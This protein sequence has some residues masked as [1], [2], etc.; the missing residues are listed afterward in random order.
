MSSPHSGHRSR[1]K[2]R[3][4]VTGMNGFSQHEK[5]ELILFY[6]NPRG[7]VNPLAHRLMEKYHT[8]SAIFDAPF[9]ELKNIEGVGEH[10][11]TFLKLIPDLC[12]EYM[13]EIESGSQTKLVT[14]QDICNF[15]RY[16]FIGIKEEVLYAVYMDNTCKVLK[17]EQISQGNVSSLNINV[18]KL[19]EIALSCNA[20]TVAIAHNHPGGALHPSAE[21]LEAT[22]HIVE[23]F[24]NL[25]IQLSDHVIISGNNYLSLRQSEEYCYVFD[26]ERRFSF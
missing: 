18:R 20:T 6:T 12:R 13:I 19:T 4:R 8:L 11:A 10:T 5:L 21:D 3:Y 17:C 24:K 7:D 22:I 16:R 23:T 25:G 2:E 1:M 14:S 9:E 26:R 15:V